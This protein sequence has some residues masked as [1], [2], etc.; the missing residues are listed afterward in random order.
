MRTVTLL[1]VVIVLSSCDSFYHLRYRHLKKVP[2]LPVVFAVPDRSCMVPDV[3]AD[4]VEQSS[5]RDTSTFTP[6]PDSTAQTQINVLPVPLTEGKRSH[7]IKPAEQE[8][9]QQ[10]SHHIPARR[11]FSLAIGVLLIALG[12]FLLVMAIFVVPFSGMAVV[13]MILLEMLFGYMIWRSLGT[14]ITYVI[15]RFRKRKDNRKES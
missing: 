8:P 4:F 9:L 3:P 5:Q 2:A 13:P 12:I 6:K 15:S 14:G 1:L 10:A 7:E 11:D